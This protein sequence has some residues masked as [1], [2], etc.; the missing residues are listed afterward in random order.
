M[1]D[2]NLSGLSSRSFE[3]LIQALAVKVLGAGTIVFGDGPDGGREATFEGRM[4]YPS[5]ADPWDGYCVLQAKFRQH[6]RSELLHHI[7]P[8]TLQL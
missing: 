1:G 8:V 6:V 3:K 7:P 4:D 2:Y 5:Q